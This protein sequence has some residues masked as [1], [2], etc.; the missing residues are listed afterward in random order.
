MRTAKTVLVALPT[1]G[2][3]T[4]LLLA[5]AQGAGSLSLT[6]AIVEHVARTGDVG[7]VTVANATGKAVTVT[8]TPRPW[9]QSRTGAVAPDRR[10]RLGN[11]A[12]SVRSFSL[13][14]GARRTVS[15]RLLKG[16]KGGSLFGAVEVVGLPPKVKTTRSGIIAAY[17][18]IGS[19][20]LTPLTA[21]RTATAGRATV[22]GGAAVLAVRNT[23]NTVDPIAGRAVL[24][25]ARGSKT[26]TVRGVRVLPG[27]TVDLNLGSV[28]GLPKGAYRARVSLTQGGQPL[29]TVS[30]ALRVR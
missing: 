3:L 13:P 19:L 28:K 11:V 10:R 27:R 8:V 23:G 14:A 17:R 12:V 4:P 18:L 25:G 26:V 9:T 20:R 24:R 15:L 21:R 7:A 6:P 22:R 29:L 30:R 5:P 1:A 2:L 16:A